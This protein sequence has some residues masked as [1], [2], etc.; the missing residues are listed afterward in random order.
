MWSKEKRSTTAFLTVGLLVLVSVLISTAFSLAQASDLKECN[1]KTITSLEARTSYSANIAR[2][3]DQRNSALL[4]LLTASSSS[5]Q[6]VDLV[7]AIREGR[8]WTTARDNLLRVLQRPGSQ[9]AVLDALSAYQKA[10]TDQK[11][12]TAKRDKVKLPRLK[13]CL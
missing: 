13:D 10:D 9:R 1:K 8:D 7:T 2:L 12:L 6:G 11:V 4:S 5:S 3:D